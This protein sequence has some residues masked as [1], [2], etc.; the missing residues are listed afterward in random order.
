MT[1]DTS[2]AKRR[3]L[4]VNPDTHA[5]LPQRSRNGYDPNQGRKIDLLWI[6]AKTLRDIRI[7]LKLED[8]AESNIQTMDKSIPS[9]S[10]HTTY[11]GKEQI[12][13]QCYRKVVTE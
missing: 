4:T 10:H 6:M 3:M 1:M 12:T 2:E 5:Q 11:T 7:L 9:L 13:Q 8:A